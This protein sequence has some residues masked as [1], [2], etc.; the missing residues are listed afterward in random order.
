M[1]KLVGFIFSI[2]I[3]AG[4]SMKE[5]SQPIVKYTIDDKE[6]VSKVI[7]KSDKILKIVRFKAPKYMHNSNIWYERSTYETN[8][9]LYSEWNEDFISL[10]E[11]NIANTIFDS[12]LFKSSFTKYSKSKS[13]FLLEG[14]IIEAVQKI[15]K[16]L[17]AVVSFKIRLYL[18]KPDDGKLI[19]LKEFSYTKNCKTIDAKGAIMAYNEIIKNLNKDVIAWLKI[20]VTKN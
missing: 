2:V 11:R 19:G 4:C 7:K 17:L 3:F 8:S 5:V 16:N 18:I 12:A 15:D 10:I 13:D 1:S 6:K 9:Y 14:E 20:L